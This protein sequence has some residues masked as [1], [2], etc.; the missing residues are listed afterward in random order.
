MH[1]RT[2][3]FPKGNHHSAAVSQKGVSGV[4]SIPLSKS[5]GLGLSD[6]DTCHHIVQP[7]KV[8]FLD[9]SGWD[10][11]ARH[12]GLEKTSNNDSE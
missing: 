9:R 6:I 5:V 1:V 12:R 10:L 3:D 7:P 2:I 8:A 4:S 11:L